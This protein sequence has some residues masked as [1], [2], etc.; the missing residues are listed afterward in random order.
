MRRI[1]ALLL[2]GPAMMTLGACERSSWSEDCSTTPSLY[3]CNIAVKGTSFNDLPFPLSG[4]AGGKIAD[5]FR[6]EEAT[7]GTARFSAGGTKGGTFTCRTG[8]TVTVADS[9]ITCT[10]V[11]ETSLKFTVKRPR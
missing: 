10:E 6:L 9:T 4:P 8:E 11:G 7:G 2:L 5:K 3:S 1:T